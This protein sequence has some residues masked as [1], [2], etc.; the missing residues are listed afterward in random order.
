VTFS[1]HPD[2]HDDF[3]FEPTGYVEPALIDRNAP[4]GPSAVS[5][6]DRKGTGELQLGNLDFAQTN[7][8]HTVEDVPLGASG[9]GAARFNGVLDNTEVFF[10]TMDALALDA[11]K[12]ATA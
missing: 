8:V 2:F 10:G 5:N 3:R 1:N 11:R 7:C 9:P 12:V 6:P 4:N